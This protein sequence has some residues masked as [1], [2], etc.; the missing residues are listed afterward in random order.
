MKRKLLLIPL[1]A[2]MAVVGCKKEPSVIIPPETPTLNPPVPADG[3]ALEVNTMLLSTGVN[4]IEVDAEQNCWVI[5]TK[6]PVDGDW[7]T[8]H[9]PWF[10]ITSL[11]AETMDFNK[12]NKLTFKIKGWS[13]DESKK[14]TDQLALTTFLVN[15]KADPNDFTGFIWLTHGDEQDILT[16][17]PNDWQTVEVDLTY[18]SY[19]RSITPYDANWNSIRVRPGLDPGGE[20]WYVKDFQ[21]VP[22]KTL[23]GPLDMTPTATGGNA[24]SMTGSGGSAG[25]EVTA[26]SDADP[27]FFFEAPENI[28]FSR[29]Q[30]LEFEVLSNAAALPL[31]ISL[32]ESTS[33][34]T[35]TDWVIPVIGD[36]NWEKVICNISDLIAPTD[37]V[38]KFRIGLPANTAATFKIRNIKFRPFATGDPTK[39]D[40]I[41]F[42]IRTAEGGTQNITVAAG[43][44]AGEYTLTPSANAGDEVW[45]FIDSK[46]GPMVIDTK[47]K[48]L[49]FEIRKMDADIELF[50]MWCG[51]FAD[52]GAYGREYPVKQVSGDDWEKVSLDLST[53]T[54]P[55]PWTWIR[56][57]FPPNKTRPTEAFEI[58]N[59]ELG[60][61]TA[62]PAVTVDLKIPTDAEIK[63]LLNNDLA[64]NQ[65]DEITVLQDGG[66]KVDWSTTGTVAGEE[67]YFYIISDNIV[68]TNGKILAMDVRNAAEA[69]GSLEIMWNT[70]S[71]VGTQCGGFP[72][73]AV[74]STTWKTLYFDLSNLDPGATWQ[75][76]KMVSTGA[77]IGNGRTPTFE[78]KNIRMLESI[79]D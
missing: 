35:S 3:Y 14:R 4:E 73:E 76:I 15:P 74:D 32:G 47:H 46:S 57:T 11:K 12:Y 22:G 18:T 25:W 6:T 2:L 54:P 42:S 53:I 67:A 64:A 33:A 39:D 50:A 69:T 36:N 19:G 52:W 75:Y 62:P 21:I 34:P 24:V 27:Y 40:P 41:S 10:Y 23:Q 45:F 5:K 20:T 79:P 13:R 43:A 59:I 77:N 8:A 9:D 61:Y 65:V 30:V 29:N 31:S 26:A 17:S 1:L 55:Q 51:G 63:T 66:W 56:V 68:T 28:D 37:A 58:R 16:D 60:E 72:M 48:A 38:K 7:S 71:W 44:T 49:N 70:L 78:V